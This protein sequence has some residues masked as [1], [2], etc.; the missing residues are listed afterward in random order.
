MF[1]CGKKLPVPRSCHQILLLAGTHIAHLLNPLD[2]VIIQ[3][4]PPVCLHAHLLNP[5]NTIICPKSMTSCLF[6][7]RKTLC[8]PDK[9]EFIL[10]LRENREDECRE[11][12]QETECMQCTSLNNC[13]GS[14]GLAQNLTLPGPLNGSVPPGDL[15]PASATSRSEYAS[16]QQ[17]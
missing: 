8:L 9:W 5:L 14:L 4:S 3:P 17:F 7:K 1:I 11:K 10:F 15:L 13:S 12:T 2:P 16:F 6:N